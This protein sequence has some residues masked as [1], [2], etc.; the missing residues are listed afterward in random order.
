MFTQNHIV[1]GLCRNDTIALGS[2]YF[3]ICI[4]TR[5]VNNSF[6]NNEGQLSESV[7]HING[8][9]SG[10]T[11]EIPYSIML[12]KVNEV[13]DL[14]VPV[15][16]AATHVEP[17][18]ILLGGAASYAIRNGTINAQAVHI[19]YI[20]EMLTNDGVLLHYPKGHCDH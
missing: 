15:C 20:Q 17:H 4:V 5:T 11:F 3:E 12:P 10:R 7:S 9:Q 1:N 18:F 8:P 13:T 19:N 2:W 16:Y 6:V 14:L